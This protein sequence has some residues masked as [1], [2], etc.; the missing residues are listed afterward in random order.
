MHWSR[1]EDLLERDVP[2]S[3]MSLPTLIMTLAPK[4][5]FFIQLSFPLRCDLVRALSLFLS[6]SKYQHW[7][8][9]HYTVIPLQYSKTVE[10]CYCM[11]GGPTTNVNFER[12]DEKSYFDRLCRHIRLFASFS[13]HLCL[14]LGQHNLY[15]FCQNISCFTQL[16]FRTLNLTYCGKSRLTKPKLSISKRKH[17]KLVTPCE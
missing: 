17:G 4:A 10:Y 7:T 14:I 5:N 1:R 16:R 15:W 6:M 13:V 9:H 8:L 12:C 11:I 3:R 2:K